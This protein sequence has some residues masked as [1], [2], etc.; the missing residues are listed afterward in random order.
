MHVIRKILWLLIAFPAAALLIAL[1]VANRHPVALKLDPFKPDN[2]LIQMTLP[3]YG[4]VFGALFAGMALGGVA[5]WLGQAK[6]RRKLRERTQ[7]AH[8]WHSEAHTLKRQM[9]ASEV[10]ARGLPAPTPGLEPRRALAR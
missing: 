3:L 5:V 1:A 6:W 4:Y 7:E 9:Q 8:R 10:I 2:P